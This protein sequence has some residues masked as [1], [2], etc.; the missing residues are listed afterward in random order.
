[1]VGE[2]DELG[3][4]PGPAVTPGE[5]A[6]TLY[7]GLGIDPHK[8]LPG[9]QNRPLPLVDYNLSRSPNCSEPAYTGIDTCT[10]IDSPS[11]CSSPA[12]AAPAAANPIVYP[13][14]VDISGPNRTQQLL[15]VLGEKDRVISD[16][17][18]HERS[19]TRPTRRWQEW[20]RGMAA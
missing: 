6:A 13:P 8:E 5:V 19:I 12:P 20:M 11:L 2:S 1:M 10:R 14:S 17:T 16:V 9:P 3:C 15:V 7:R 4:K 18:A